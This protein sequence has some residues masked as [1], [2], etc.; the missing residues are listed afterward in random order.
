MATPIMVGTPACA[1]HADRERRPLRIND[2]NMNCPKILK[3]PFVQQR[4]TFIKWLYPSFFK[5]GLD[6]FSE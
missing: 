2:Q 5:V 3:T 6:I 4:V 1:L